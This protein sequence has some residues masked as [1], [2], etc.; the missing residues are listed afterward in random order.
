MKMLDADEAFGPGRP[1]R[2]LVVA[3]G[4][5]ANTAL[6]AALTDLA[7]AYG[8]TFHAPPISL[9][10]DNAAMIAWAGA[11]RFARGITDDL[12]APVRPRWPLDREAA[13]A[14]GAGAK[15]AKA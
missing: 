1:T 8:Y 13:P 9:C 5:A 15:G 2:H 3:G 6:R 11:E 10:G 12:D 7:S 14:L 4:V